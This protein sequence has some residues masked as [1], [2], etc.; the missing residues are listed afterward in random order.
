MKLE[1][2]DWRP[3]KPTLDLVKKINTILGPSPLPFSVKQLYYSLVRAKVLKNSRRDYCQY[4]TTVVKA[5]MAG[6]IDWDKISDKA[7]FTDFSPTGTTV[8]G[9]RQPVY[10]EVWC[11]KAGIV[12]TLRPL[13]AR[14]AIPFVWET[15]HYSAGTIYA[16]SGRIGPH[17]SNGRRCRILM[18]GDFEKKGNATFKA[19]EN[20]LRLML[21]NLG[22]RIDWEPIGL[23]ESQVVEMKLPTHSTTRAR[24][25][26]DLVEIETLTPLELQKILLSAI[27]IPKEKE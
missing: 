19:A 14:H 21:P 17:V 27:E 2:I 4:L 18:F 7:H 5:R 6:M 13:L 16:A 1:L 11:A 15:G 10:T 24:K 23:T 12:E 25:K 9:P 26:N 8:L 22:H 20:R 3:K